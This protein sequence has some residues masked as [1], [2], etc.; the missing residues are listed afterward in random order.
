MGRKVM[1]EELYNLRSGVD[2]IM[3]LAINNG[4]EYGE[5]AYTGVLYVAT[6]FDERTDR[7]YRRNFIIVPRFGTLKS[8]PFPLKP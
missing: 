1:A 7:T 8:R 4:S 6:H 3:S 2:A 5:D